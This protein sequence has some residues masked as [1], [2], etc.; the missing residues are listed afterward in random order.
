MQYQ[1]YCSRN[2]VSELS[3]SVT[4][5]PEGR[6]VFRAAPSSLFWGMLAVLALTS[7][8]LL[9]LRSLFSNLFGAHSRLA[10]KQVRDRSLGGRMV[11]IPRAPGRQLWFEQQSNQ[12]ISPLETSL[13]TR[14]EGLSTHEARR[15]NGDK[16][17]TSRQQLPSW[18]PHNEPQSRQSGAKS[19]HTSPAQLHLQGKLWFDSV[20][21]A[22]PL[23]LITHV[24]DVQ[25]C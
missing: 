21:S 4:F 24:A 20:M 25:K 7:A 2:V 1:C 14:F 18:W 9:L 19:L 23:C 12:P 5:D 6:L 15:L 8:S 17:F 10:A 11:T 16:L 22:L 3:N 13:A